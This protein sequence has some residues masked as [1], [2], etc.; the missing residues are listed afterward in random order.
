MQRVIKLGG[1]LLQRPNLRQ[2]IFD[3]LEKEPPAT[4][5]VIVGGGGIID[6]VRDF[7]SVHTPDQELIHWLCV[8]LLSA[9]Q[10]LVASVFPEWVNITD[11]STLLAFTARRQ[12]QKTAIIAVKTF[13]SADQ[14]HGL[15][16]DWNTTTDSI[17]AALA[18]HVD[19]DELV[20]FKSC[21]ITH[22]DTKRMIKEGILDPT[23][24]KISADVR[25]IRVV[26]P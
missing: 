5:F 21:E 18:V 24:E 26:S 1:S 13:Y 17:A 9:T 7:D 22:N 20:L 4:N 19:A 12:E 23:F 2:V 8:D 25:K 10:S 11:R 15:S 3:W 6:A 14:D 16:R